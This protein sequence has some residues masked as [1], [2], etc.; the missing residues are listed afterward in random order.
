MICA[1]G[2]K[3]A[4]AVCFE[5]LFVPYFVEPRKHAKMA[6]QIPVFPNTR[7][8]VTLGTL[9]TIVVVSTVLRSLAV[10]EDGNM[11]C[12]TSIL[13][14]VVEMI[15]LPSTPG[16]IVKIRLYAILFLLH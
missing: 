6:R 9:H 10:A 8:P 5:I 15:C 16:Q 11:L 1:K 12:E 2:S 4:V 13:P 7:L 14:L 3:Y